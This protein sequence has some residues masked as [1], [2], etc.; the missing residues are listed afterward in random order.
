MKTKTERWNRGPDLALPMLIA[1]GLHV[2]CTTPAS[3]Q[4]EAVPGPTAVRLVLQ[5]TVDQ[6]RGDLPFRY[7][8]RYGPDGFRYLIEEGTWY[9]DAHHGHANTET[10]VGHTTLATGAQPAAHG[11]IGNLWVDRVSGEVVYNIEDPDHALLTE[12]AGVDAKSE[13]DPTQKAARAEGRSPAAIQVPTFGDTLAAHER[14]LSKVFGVS[15]K[16]RGAVSLA[17]HAGK[18]FWFSKAGGEFVTSTYYYDRYPAWVEA[19]NGSGAVAAYGDGAWE[20]ANERSTYFFGDAD[21][22]PWETA[23]GSYGRVFP[24]PFGPADGRY[25]TTLLTLSPV[26]DQLTLD[27]AKALI[28]GEGLGQDAIPD[29]LSVSF[30][31]TDY[32]G[33]LFG[34]SSLEA[35]DNLL[36]LD[37]RLSELF[38]FVDERVGL[39]HTLIVLSADHGG[40]EVPGYLE[41]LGVP[42]SY[43]PATPWEG[44]ELTVGEYPAADLIE[45][46]VHPYV[47]LDLAAIADRGLDVAQVERELAAELEQLEAVH[48]AVPT[49]DLRSGRIALTPVTEAVLRNDYRGRSGDVYLVLKPNRFPSDFDGLQVAA[50]HGSVWRYDT[51]VPIAFAGAAVPARVVQRRVHTVD[52][53]PTLSAYLRID[54]PAGASGVPLVEV[55]GD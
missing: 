18:A 47:Y 35:E 28:E 7:L 16:D 26:G 4:D 36:A 32:V 5:I 37:R 11:M 25:F 8:D 43:V 19:W 6:L 13:L 2:S 33:H 38:R 45:A 12:G 1:L 34:P 42:A 21:D 40:P 50:T 29:Y 31:S 23:F 9:V 52:V 3:A 44:T 20:L 54:P 10:I 39:E 27:F 53:A 22:A 55:L 30:S 51:H 17:G 14:G 24:H 46:Y 41:S 48:Q 49:E 15:V